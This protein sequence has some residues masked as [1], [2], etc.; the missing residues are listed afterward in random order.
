M[1]IRL[2]DC[3]IFLDNEE[4]D[5]GDLFHFVLIAESETMN[6]EESLSDPKWICSMKEE[7]KS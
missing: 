4:T 6:S 5:K 3:D 2:M 1:P 7:L